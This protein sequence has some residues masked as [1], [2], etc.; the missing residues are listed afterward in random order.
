MHL[1]AVISSLR[2]TIRS[3]DQFVKE[4]KYSEYVEILFA[5]FAQGIK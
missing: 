5:D 2:F 4:D 3:T 1:I